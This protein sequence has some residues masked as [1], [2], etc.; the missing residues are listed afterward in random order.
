ME[1]GTPVADPMARLAVEVSA[2]PSADSEELDQLVGQLRRELLEL[3]VESVDRARG[4]PVPKGARA[5]DVLAL[6]TLLVSLVDPATV[7]P[8]VVAAVQAWLGGRGQRSV[9]LELDGD[10]LEVTG[11]S[12]R[13]QGR[14]ID[15]WL[16]RHTRGT[17]GSRWQVAEA[18]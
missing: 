7:L 6:G 2:G 14:L 16:D 10:V 8:A 9:K 17:E 12:S 1:G 15:G 3:E 5:V 18:H 4:G 11:L 13:D